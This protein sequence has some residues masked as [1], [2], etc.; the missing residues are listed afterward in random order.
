MNRRARRL[1]STLRTGLALSV[2]LCTAAETDLRAQVAGQN[3]NMVS[4]TKWPGGDP[5]LQRQNEPSLAV[6]SRNQ[7]HLMAGANDY[8]TVDLPTE[9]GSVPG[10]LSGDAWLGVFKS[11]DGGLSW[12]S[13]LLPGY[14][15]D[16]STI[17]KASPLK[18]YSAAADPTVRAGANGLV[19]YSG[20]A[21]NRGTNIGAVF[22]T[23][24]FDLNNKENGDATDPS[25]AKDPIAFVD[26]KLI[27][28][29]TSGQFLDKPW[30]AVDVPR[31][32][33]GATTCSVA[34]SGGTAQTFVGGN[35]Y[36]TW[37]RFTGS[38]S[39]KIMF[40]RSVDCGKTWATPIKISESNSINQGTNIA[41]DPVSGAVYV[42][43]R[44]FATSSQ[45]DAIIVSKSNDFGQTFTSKNTVLVTTIAPFDQGTSGTRF[46]T[47]ALP[48][49]A[50]SVDGSGASRVHIAWAQRNATSQNA[51]I[52]V[53]T[54]TDGLSWPT[55][56][57]VVDGNALRDDSGT[58]FGSGHQFMPQVTFSQGRLMVL[59]YDQRL[60]HT[61]GLFTPNQPF[62]PDA[63]GNF[64]KAFRSSRPI[65]PK[66]EPVAVFGLTID[67]LGLQY[68][69]HTIDLR[70]AEAIPGG[71]MSFRSSS[72]SQYK[73]GLR[74]N[75][76]DEEGNPLAL[77]IT[78]LNQ[79]QS[80][81]PNLP[82]F[83]QGTVPFLGDYIDIAGPTIVQNG[84]GSWKF[85][86]ALAAAPVFYATWTDNRDVTAP[87]DGDWTHYTPP[88]STT[89]GA[90]SVLDPTKT[91]SPC[92]PGQE[93]MRNQNVYSSRIT[94]GL[95]VGSPQNIKP[96]FATP[97]ARAFI[98]TLQNLTAQDR[99][100]TMS[101]APGAG[102]AASFQQTASTG[103]LTVTVPARSG[104]AR[105]VFAS[106]S[107]PAGSVA[108]NVLESGPNSTGLSGSV[109]LNPEGTVSPLAQPDGSTTDIGTIEIYTPTLS[110]WNPVNPN[111]FL[112]IADPNQNISNQNISNQNISNADPAIQN[113][114]NQN[115]SNQNISNQNISNPDPAV[116][117]ISNQNISN[118]NI[119]NQNISN[120]NISNTT[121]TD[122][123]YAVTN[124]GNTTHSY[125]IA[126]YGTNTT[127][128]PLQLIVTKNYSSPA[129]VG[130]AL[131]NAPQ[132]TI[133]ANVNNALIAPTLAAATDPDIPD[134]A[135]TNATMALAPGETA[136]ITL[137][138]AMTAGQM[139]QLT[140]SLTPVITAHGKSGAAN[141]FAALLFIQTT[142]GS[143]PVAVVGVPYSFTFTSVGGN[144]TI[145]WTS[146][147]ALPA[148]LS[149]SPGGVL[150]GTPSAAGTFTFTVSAAD[151]SRTP[152]SSTQS[153]TMTVAA[154]TTSTTVSF[155]ASP[156]VVGQ[157]V[158]VTVTVTDTQSGGTSSSPSGIVALSGDP[159]LSAANCTLV[160]ATSSTS[161]CGVTVT[162]TTP[163]SRTIS[164]SFPA[165]TV[166]QVS[167]SGSG[168]NVNQATTTTAILATPSPSVPGQPVTLSATVSVVAPGAG[169]P[170][171]TITFF[172]GSAT[173]GTG[174]ISSG[175]ATLTAAALTV[176]AHSIKATYAGDPNFATSTSAVFSQIVNQAATATT[177]SAA[178][179]SSIFGQAVTLSASV[180]VVAPG[181]GS[182]TGTVTFYDGA[183]ALG[184]TAISG[185]VATLTTSALTGGGHSIKAMY[186]GD[187][188]FSG[189]T[190]AVLTQTVAR[191]PTSTVLVTAP[192]PSVL[193][194]AVTLT[195]A[196]TTTASG[197]PGPAGSVTFFDGGTAI[198]TAPLTGSLATFSTA[199]LSIGSHVI[200]AT[201][202]GDVNYGGSS[203]GTVAQVVNIPPYA[204]TG[205]GSPLS[206]PGTLSSP[207]YSGTQNF[208]SATPIKYQLLDSLGNIVSDLSSTTSIQAIANP[209]CSG[210]A[211]GPS[212]LLY[213]PT[214][215][216]TGGSTFRFS[217]PGFTFNWDTSVVPGPGCYTIVLQLNDASAPRATT[218]KLQ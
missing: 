27:D 127:N 117:N 53:A 76:S 202:A 113:I 111:P 34:P 191:A 64:Y 139:A 65:S 122:S 167:G 109:V 132:T 141:E 115:I 135:T 118:Q 41:V 93:G 104:A 214:V 4:G 169:S 32:G 178:P 71:T 184:T 38:T 56:F 74:A 130:C 39:T 62:S 35:V 149:L 196:V 103:I 23:R 174:T 143:L 105:P 72:V 45:P 86:T 77:P 7:I 91:T 21:F 12:Q 50:A 8:R 155:G 69:R 63:N 16:Q 164:A 44:R 70:V 55:P 43:W 154:R 15:Q 2:L 166:H 5:F 19:Y 157:A 126:L 201:Y 168:L 217:S 49:I 179:S 216:A 213:S 20:M 198:G 110:T 212:V 68:R 61:L 112:S 171:G 200:T 199:A 192:N 197:V 123:T 195:A 51:Q 151:G 211:T 175:V 207:T 22:L 67:D 203:S 75:L 90:P 177:S 31:S 42:A 124:S 128:A 185:N 73:V 36:M 29:G 186:N 138:G 209:S 3:I 170:G 48:S 80:N 78:S 188:S 173:L 163:G 17:G 193:G 59:Y 46:R 83:A 158:P 81:P 24:Y 160:P 57:A 88:G 66:V 120:Q 100:F 134:G 148:G 190:S 28:T 14:P 205:F 60:D 25:Q 133:L 52:V 140:R 125:R 89:T 129:S 156:A 47:N 18:A 131:Q 182:P 94:E 146:S 172:D 33:S 145:T 98:I 162:P 26:T 6:S 37:S 40:T 9:P 181:A 13:T 116:Q 95:V 97:K 180:A 165:T 121:I 189:S 92:A 176:G 79:L 58:L 11:F 215:G 87:R 54:S 114:S 99:T 142:S 187:T 84:A 108:V 183:A 161:T 102:V 208:G 30:I 107:N 85:N 144:G 150:S 119:S 159:G 136:F 82:L 1:A 101:L 96:L 194:Q 218:I 153:I 204:F 147:G 10:T 152:E 106:S 137:R 206:T 210:A